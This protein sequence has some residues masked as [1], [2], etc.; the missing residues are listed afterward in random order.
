MDLGNA[1][2]VGA[3][4]GAASNAVGG[5]VGS[6]TSAVLARKNREWNEKM[7]HMQ[8]E[9][10]TPKAQMQR[11]REAGLNPNLAY[12]QLA[13]SNAGQVGSAD[14]YGNKEISQQLS[15]LNLAEAG[16]SIGQALAQMK[17]TQSE[18][19][20]Q[21]LD[22]KMKAIDLN[23]KEQELDAIATYAQTH[24]A[25]GQ[26]MASE[27]KRLYSI[28][29]VWQWLNDIPGAASNLDARI[30]GARYFYD[31]LVYNLENIVAGK[32]LKDAQK[33]AT[34]AIKN[35]RLLDIPYYS[36][37]NRWQP[38]NYGIESGSK[39]INSLTGGFGNVM[40]SLPK[41]KV[42]YNPNY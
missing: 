34:D 41:P 36:T 42:Q 16:A 1:T 25:L 3:G 32:N 7:W 15:R 21:Q 23:F 14:V 8:N 2:M 29:G 20:G 27:G 39:I 10:N 4:I 19:E 24:S 12:G 38:W 28:N 31:K 30:Y 11:L 26:K 5:I 9:Y 6:I 33:G 18:A 35:L 37:R 17:K 22:N 13:S 40:R